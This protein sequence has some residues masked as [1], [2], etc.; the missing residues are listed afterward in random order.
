MAEMKKQPVIVTGISKDI[1]L[2]GM[3]HVYIGELTRDIIDKD[4][5]I[6]KIKV[7][8]QYNLINKST[9]KIVEEFVK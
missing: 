3:K 5:H 4:G 7:A 2:K 9:G 1:Q 6:T 8:D